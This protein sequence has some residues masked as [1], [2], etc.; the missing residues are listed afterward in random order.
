[1]SSVI[2]VGCQFGDEGK[3]RIVD[4]LAENADMVV[5]F[6]GG[7][8]A[9]HTIVFNGEEYKLNL[10]PAGILHK[11]VKCVLG[12]GMV[13]DLYKIVD[14]INSLEKRGVS[15]ENL[16]ISDRAHIILPSHVINDK[17][18]EDTRINKIGTT[19]KGIGPAYKDKVGRIGIRICD[20]ELNREKLYFLILNN[21]YLLN[22][23]YTYEQIDNLISNFKEIILP[24]IKN[25]IINTSNYINKSIDNGDRVLFEGAQGLLIDV[26]H[27]TYPYVTSSNSSSGG[28]CTGSGVGP[29]KI[30][31]TLGVIKA[32]TTR[33]GEGPFPTELFDNTANI[34]RNKGGEWGTTT[35][36]SRRCGWLDMVALKYSSEVNG[37][38]SIAI[39]KL[40]ILDSMDEIKVCV[41]YEIDGENHTTFPSNCYV[42]DKVKPIYISFA[43]WKTDTTNIRK[44]ENLP[45]KAKEYLLYISSELS[46]PISM[47][48]V[49]PDRYQIIGENF[50][51]MDK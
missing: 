47:I 28:V 41:A 38:N 6:G 32:Y 19:G 46:L 40:D 17:K 36:R 45:D 43:G 30:N 25:K 33:V 7:N 21:L 44:W 22:I 1:M 9:G 20:L 49:G 18:I 27:G 11:E 14:E 39:T 4:L 51:E 5:R 48:G 34:L 2:V 10:I 24:K 26:D 8:N 35:G 31:H 13:I 3:A 23:S 42:L 15:T 29:T 12:N 50:W 16:Y 37:L